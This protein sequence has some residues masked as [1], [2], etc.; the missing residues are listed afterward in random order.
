[1]LSVLGRA[2]LD[3]VLLIKSHHIT[4]QLCSC[5]H[6]LFVQLLTHQQQYTTGSY[7]H[8]L[9]CI[10]VVSAAEQCSMLVISWLGYTMVLLHPN[11]NP[12]WY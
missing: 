9:S 8:L 1:V 3:P 10:L 5:I 6:T 7:V 4:Y 12:P 2:P 11:V